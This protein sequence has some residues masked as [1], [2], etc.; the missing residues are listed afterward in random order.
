VQSFFLRTLLDV[1][2]RLR[3][4]VYCIDF[5]LIPH[6]PSRS[7]AESSRTRADIGDVLSRIDSEDV[8]HPPNLQPLVPAR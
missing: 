6:S 5:P 8:H 7:H 1:M 2:N 4:D 3:V